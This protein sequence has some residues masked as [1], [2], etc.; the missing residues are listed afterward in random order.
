M[1]RKPELLCVG[2]DVMLNRTRQ[3][4]FEK[5]FQVKLAHTEAE[6]MA[7]LPEQQFDLVLLCYSLHDED[8]RRIVEAVHSL[9]SPPKILSMAEG[10]EGLLGPNDEEF[11]SGG[12]ADLLKRA[13]AMAG[14]SPDEAE[15]CA[16]QDP[17]QKL[18]PSIQ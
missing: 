1:S 9:P 17:G 5:C 12:P 3:L 2:R 4:I 18:G 15:K 7:L 14:L 8:S 16:A 11:L 10:H 6:A 13:A